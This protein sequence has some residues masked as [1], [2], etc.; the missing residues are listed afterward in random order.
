MSSVVSGTAQA[1]HGV[2]ASILMD[3]D[4]GQNRIGLEVRIALECGLLEEPLA[5]FGASVLRKLDEF[6]AFS[7][8]LDEVAVRKLG[9]CL[10]KT[11]GMS[12]DANL[13]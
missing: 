8:I 12:I 4:G 10:S 11:D 1:V 7:S 2:Y 13:T 3:F 5:E 9:G 6:G